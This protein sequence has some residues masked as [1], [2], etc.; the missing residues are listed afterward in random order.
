MA[1]KRQQS[2]ESLFGKVVAAVRWFA[3]WMD[4]CAEYRGSAALY[5]QLSRLSDDE[6]HKRGLTRGVSGPLRF[7]IAQI[8]RWAG[9][10]R[11]TYVAIAN[12]PGTLK[13]LQELVRS[14][15]SLDVVAVAAVLRSSPVRT[16]R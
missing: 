9:D 14:P 4:A 10:V 13:Y 3:A 12:H 2:G 11:E 15:V 7:Q 1:T 5:E 8:D 16:A 6:L